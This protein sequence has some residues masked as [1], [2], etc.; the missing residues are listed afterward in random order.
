M[1]KSKKKRSA[2]PLDKAL[3]G[4]TAAKKRQI[5]KAAIAACKIK[6]KKKPAKRKSK[7]RSKKRK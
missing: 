1:A 4:L 7:A 3:T 5:K 6:A 2:N